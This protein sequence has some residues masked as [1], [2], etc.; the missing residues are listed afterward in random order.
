VAPRPLD[1]LFGRRAECPAT[2]ITALAD[3]DR[4]TGARPE[5]APAGRSLATCLRAAFGEP[6]TE[7]VPAPDPEPI[8][9]AWREGVPAFR[10]APP[11][12]DRAGLDARALAVCEALRGENPSSGPLQ[13]ALRRGR[14]DLL[15][16]W[17]AARDGSPE[18]IEAQATASGLNPSLLVSVLRLALLPALARFAEALAPIRAEFPWSRGLCPYCGQEPVIAESRGLEQRRFLRCGLCAAEW[19]GDRLRCPFCGETDSHSLAYR[20]VEGEQDRYRLA[21]CNGCGGRLKVVSTLVPISPPGLL[22]AELATVHLDLI[23]ERDE[24]RETD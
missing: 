18:A 20:F 6:P 2:L 10:V 11:P 17:D 14:A 13:T 7:S 16:G 23:A 24:P 19:P 12:L 15:A 3:L 8:R 9:A 1:R 5:L 22:V 21:L 4:L